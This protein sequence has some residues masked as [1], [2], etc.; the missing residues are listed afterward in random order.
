M[1]RVLYLCR[2]CGDNDRSWW[3]VYIKEIGGHKKWRPNAWPLQILMSELER[4]TQFWPQRQLAG[5]WLSFCQDIFSIVWMWKQGLNTK[6][7]TANGFV[8]PTSLSWFL[9]D[10]KGLQ[11]TLPSR[12]VIHLVLSWRLA[13]QISS[14]EVLMSERRPFLFTAVLVEGTLMQEPEAGGSRTDFPSVYA[15][16]PQQSPPMQMG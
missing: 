7:F 11:L 4:R 8:G 13:G 9:I 10:D 1:S 12:V 14:K 5:C 15:L 2:L 6:H 3:G 16:R